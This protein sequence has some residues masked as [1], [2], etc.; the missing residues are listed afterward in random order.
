MSYGMISEKEFFKYYTNNG[1][2]NRKRFFIC[3][4]FFI[5]NLILFNSILKYK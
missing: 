3:F 5:S 1:D 2:E 4:I